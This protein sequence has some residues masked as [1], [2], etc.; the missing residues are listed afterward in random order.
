MSRKIRKLREA[1]ETARR[2]DDHEELA[3]LYEQLE[4]AEPSEPEW[5]KRAAG[6]FARIKQQDQ[7]LA[8]LLRAA[9]A[10]SRAGFLLKAVAVC[11][12]ILRIDPGHTVTQARLAELHSGR[13]RDLQRVLT[14]PEKIAARS[15]HIFP[16]AR[17]K[18]RS[19]RWSWSRRPSPRPPQPLS[20]SDHPRPSSAALPC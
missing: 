12:R 19:R 4:R 3:R 14:E 11:K 17:S 8:A 18:R 9:E 13:K 5:P 15:P 6:A 2:R 1:A 7:E 16:P 20:S 10:Y